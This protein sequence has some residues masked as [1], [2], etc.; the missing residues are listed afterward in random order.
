MI[1]AV[2]P[3]DGRYQNKTK[4][5]QEYFSEYALIKY[6]VKVEIEYLILLIN[7]NL[8]SLSK[9]EK[10]LAKLRNIYTDFNEQDA[11]KIKK[12]E[13]VTNHDVKAVEYFVKEKL[14]ALGFA[15]QQEWVHF[16][17]TS[18][19]INNTAVP[20]SIKDYLSDIYVPEIKSLI[21]QINDLT[22]EYRG[23]PIL[24][25]THGQA[26]SPSTLGKEFLVFEERLNN[27]LELLLKLPIKAKFGG[28]TGNFNAHKVSFPNLNW[29]EIANGFIHDLGL[30]RS[31]YTTQ[32]AHY[33]HL[34]AICHNITRINTILIDMARDI[35]TYISMDYFKQKVIANEVGSSAMP[36]KVNPIDFENAEGNLGMANALF[37]YLAEKLP[38]SRL[39]RDLTDSTVL[40][41]IGVPFGHSTIAYQSLM[42][43]L[44]KIILNESKLHQDLEDNWAVV[45]EAIQNILRREAYPKPY[46]A[47]K[48]LTRGNQAITKSSIHQFIDELKLSDEIKKEL[49]DISPHNYVGYY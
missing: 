18:Q 16:A 27:Q 38:V 21:K 34:A 22:K 39:Q 35:W 26:A 41:N 49:K 10:H 30:E 29:P 9:L 42:K 1:K 48:A 2:S 11:E 44:N 31:Q 17:L 12:I 45:A 33:D 15:D 14:E 43:G 13:S 25:R 46:E 4:V 37:N 23:I 36:H 5:L 6:R 7:N 8:G 19:D 28:A 40:R 20:L 32:I 24:A 3:I 47:L